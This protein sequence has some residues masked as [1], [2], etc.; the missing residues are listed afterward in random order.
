MKR[1]SFKSGNHYKSR[2]NFKAAVIRGKVAVAEG[3]Q[4]EKHVHQ[5]VYHYIVSTFSLCGSLGFYQGGVEP[6][7]PSKR[8][9]KD[10]KACIR[11]LDKR[12][13]RTGG[14]SKSG[15]RE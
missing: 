2:G 8:S 10:C 14:K 13:K 5:R 12:I 15:Q 6:D 3:W 9:S 7:D 4:T 11:N 1:K